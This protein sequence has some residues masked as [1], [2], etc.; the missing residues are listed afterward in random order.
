M[1][2]GRTGSFIALA[3]AA[4]LVLPTV[5]DAQSEKLRAVRDPQ[6]RFMISIPITWQ[7]KTSTR[8]PA[9]E[10]KS[11]APAGELPDTLDVIVRD[12]PRPL[13]PEACV[14]KAEQLM[15]LVIHDF[16]TLEERPDE[17]A[18]LPAYSHSYVWRT[19]TGVD[20]RSYQVC[21]TVRSRAFMMIGS[22]TNTATYVH[23]RLTT[24]SRIME[25]FRPQ[26]GP[27]EV[28]RE[29]PRAEPEETGPRAEPGETGPR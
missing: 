5:S 18:G 7:V 15:R 14:H 13:S 17:I 20:R 21:L 26:A 11:P 2:A 28:V 9:V 29:K 10:A 16:A 3:V 12:L 19:R 27:R 24:L 1:H 22:T 8:D 23:D 4:L 6:D 25:T